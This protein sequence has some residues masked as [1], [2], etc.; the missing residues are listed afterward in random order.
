MEVKVGKVKE[1]YTEKLEGNMCN[2]CTG[3]GDNIVSFNGFPEI[4]VCD[5]CFSKYYIEKKNVRYR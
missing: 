3:I 5:T 2:D 1:L 4:V